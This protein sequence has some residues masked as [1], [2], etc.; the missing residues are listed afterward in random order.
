[1]NKLNP[2]WFVSRPIDLEHKQY[3]LMA[4][5]RDAETSF[6]SNQI[7]PFFEDVRGQI[8]NLESYISIRGILKTDAYNLSEKEQEDITYIMSLPDN[9]EDQIEVNKIVKWSLKKLLSLQKTANEL[10]RVV[11]DSLSMSFVG[12]KPKK[13]KGGYLFIRYPGS[14]IVETYRFENERWQMTI[15]F[16]GYDENRKSTYADVMSK[17]DDGQE[18][19]AYIMV[20]PTKQFNTTDTLLPV[21]EHILKSKVIKN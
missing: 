12:S 16:I 18:D 8:K 4:Y 3:V 21:V 5:I 10:W 17:Y 11:E 15:E 6:M 20:E 13:I 1:M 9:H 7:R 19:Y 2:A 14:W